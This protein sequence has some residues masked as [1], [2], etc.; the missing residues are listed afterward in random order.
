MILPNTAY[1]DFK[2]EPDLKFC[3]QIQIFDGK[4]EMTK[5]QSVKLLMHSK[6]IYLP[7]PK[8]PFFFP[9][10]AEALGP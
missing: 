5:T 1:G 3:G 10:F 6:E 9:A 2:I 8:V 4:E 7:W